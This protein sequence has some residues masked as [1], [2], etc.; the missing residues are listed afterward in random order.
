[1]RFANHDGRL[2]LITAG[3]DDELDGTT[4]V[5]AQA[6]SGGRTPADPDRA[7]RGGRHADVPAQ[8][9]P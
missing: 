1:M 9:G 3:P 4:G 7:R 5:D 6:A 8:P 2:T